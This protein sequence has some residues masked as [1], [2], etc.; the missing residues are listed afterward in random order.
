MKIYASDKC[1]FYENYLKKS[2]EN[3]CNK[4]FNLKSYTEKSLKNSLYLGF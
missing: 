4:K 2:L 1:L 3:V